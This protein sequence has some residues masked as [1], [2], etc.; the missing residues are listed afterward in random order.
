MLWIRRSVHQ[1]EVKNMAEDASVC[2]QE[3]S[4]RGDP[5]IGVSYRIEER[6]DA[7]PNHRWQRN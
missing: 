2:Q 5:M 1:Q 3:V 4:V 7:K 6:H